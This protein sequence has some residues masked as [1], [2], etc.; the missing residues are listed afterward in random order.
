MDKVKNG[1]YMNIGIIYA[2]GM[3]SRMHS[4]DRP[5]QFLEIYNKPIMIYTLEWFENNSN[6][7]AIVAVCIR[8]WITYLEELV[9]KYRFEK[10]RKIVPGGKTGQDSIYNGLCAAKEISG[11]KNTIVLIHDG[12]RP[13]INDTLITKC[14]NMVKDKGSAITTGIVK[15]TLAVINEDG[16]IKEVPSRTNSRTA[17]APQCYWLKDILAAHIKA[18][19]EGIHDFLDCCTMMNYYGY[20]LHTVDGPYDNIKITT[21]DDYYTM[22]AILEARENAQIYGF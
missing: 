3:G 11:D 17:K 20:E 19:E 21:P 8:E 14:I 16:S 5:K 1:G 2:G 18:R 22:R 7:D 15:E 4:K 12:V 13:L 10:I 6:I 9:Y